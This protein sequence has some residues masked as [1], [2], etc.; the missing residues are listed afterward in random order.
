MWLAVTTMRAS[1]MACKFGL[2][3]FISRYLDL[4]SLGMYGLIV[5]AAAIGPVVICMGVS[6]VLVREAVTMTPGQLTDGL[7]HYWCFLAAA[8]ALLVPPAVLFALALN[9]SWLWTVVV[10]VMVFEHL[11]SDIFQLLSNLERPLLAN[12]S[13]FL[14]GAAWILMYVPLA[15]WNPHLRSLPVL[16]GFWLAGDILALL[17]FAGASRTWPWKSA[18]SLPFRPAWITTNIRKSLIIYVSDI[19]FVVSQYFDRYLVTLF[20]GLEFAGVY[21]LYWTVGNS[22]VTFI[23][24]AV[25]QQQRP[26]LIK[27]HH[28]GGAAAHRRL[29]A[30]FMRTIAASTLALALVLGGAFQAALPLLGQPLAADHFAAFWLI[31]A[32]MVA[33]SVADFGAS[34]LFA[35][36][37]DRLMTLTNVV[38]VAGIVLAQAAL[39]PLAGL[40]GAGAAILLTFSAITLWRHR[41][42]FGDSPAAINGRQHLFTTAARDA[43]ARKLLPS[44]PRHTEVDGRQV[45]PG[46]PN[47][48]SVRMTPRL[49]PNPE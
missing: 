15:V 14:R 11:G 26:F 3:I 17:L 46:V 40:Y 47:T 5:G 49:H 7:R 21:V 43:D 4:A 27:A 37:R 39:L 30:R 24:M 44:A 16:I 48:S 6:N 28:E 32:G 8:Y 25:V 10:V 33:R 9:G 29:S 41:L 1:V 45:W 13:A 2:A 35:A 19:S 18:F 12:I 22:V 31:M 20:L 36:R 38:A 42:L 23:S 34:A